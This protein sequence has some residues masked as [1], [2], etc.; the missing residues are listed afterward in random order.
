LVQTPGEAP[1][2]PGVHFTHTG[3]RHLLGNAPAKLYFGIWDAERPGEPVTR[4]PWGRQGLTEATAEFQRSAPDGKVTDGG[5]WLKSIGLEAS[6]L[7]PKTRQFI[8]PNLRGGDDVRFCLIGNFG[9]ALLALQDRVIVCK[10]GFMAGAS[11]GARTTAFLYSDISA[12][13]VNSG[14][15]NATVEIHTPGLGATKAGDFWS[16]G[17]DDPAKL[18]NV[19]PTGSVLVR[20]W[21]PYLDAI[22]A[23]S[24]AAKSPGP[25]VGG[26]RDV[27]AQ[28]AQLHEL[29]GAG[30]LTDEEFTTAKRRLL[31]A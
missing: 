2:V 12:I 11:F 20:F 28:I 25:T 10:P 22:Q 31:E 9:Q 26:Q 7:P 1:D 15:A 29:H 27:A 21:R 30:A 13:Q 19:V 4:F 24:A 8:E 5:V 14:L 3:T 23:W 18:P 6:F 17:K 16:S